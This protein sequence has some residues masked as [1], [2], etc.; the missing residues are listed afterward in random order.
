MARALT[1]DD[2]ERLG[3][4]GWFQR[5]SWLAPEAFCDAGR[6]V[7]DLR[8][9]RTT[10]IGRGAD[11]QQVTEVRGDERLWLDERAAPV[12]LV[13]IVGA[14]E[15]LRL[16]LNH[17]AFLGLH[18]TELQLARFHE[19]GPR[20]Q[21]HLDS[22]QGRAGRRVTAVYYLNEGWRPADEGCLRLHLASGAVDVT[23]QM[24]TLV[25][26]LS[27][28]IEHEVLLSHATR[29]ALTAWWSGSAVA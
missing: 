6:A 4:D 14:L 5:S 21:R 7:Q 18:R 20:Y 13:A 15:A 29:Y 9:Y 17:D 12:G 1:D 2:V 23:P 10:G 11:Q 19:G 16:E 25:V 22:F 24:N 27:E 28:R 8:G 26:F 3:R